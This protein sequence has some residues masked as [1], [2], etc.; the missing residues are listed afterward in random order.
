VARTRFLKGALIVIRRVLIAAVVLAA[1]ACSSNNSSSTPA[2]STTGATTT[3]STGTSSGTTTN[4][5]IPVGAISLTTTAFVPN[6]V[7]V[8]VGDSIMWVN[9]DSI[10]HTST[11]NN[12]TT[13]NSGTIAPGGSFK[14]TMTTAGTF[15]YHCAFHPGMV[16]TV[17]VQ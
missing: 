3:G 10:A 8:R 13:W 17:T 1:A 14:T 16:G 9:T 7:S 4:V 2:P 11:A 5:T 15:A 6:P 12:G